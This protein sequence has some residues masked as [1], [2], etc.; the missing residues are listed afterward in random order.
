MS[1]TPTISVLNP[2]MLTPCKGLLFNSSL[3]LKL[4]PTAI[5]ILFA[6]V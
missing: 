2:F 3:R 4:Q 5:Y 6:A 1:N